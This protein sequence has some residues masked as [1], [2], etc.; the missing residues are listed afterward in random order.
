M[1]SKV[2]ANIAVAVVSSN[3]KLA[4]VK[5]E[6]F[7]QRELGKKKKKNR[8]KERPMIYIISV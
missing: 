5:S 3:D 8:E 6:Q 2:K 4:Q 7:P 1:K